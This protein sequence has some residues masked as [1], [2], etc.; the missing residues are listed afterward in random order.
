VFCLPWLAGTWG[1][2]AEWGE[3]EVDYILF[4]KAD[5]TLQPN[6]EE[7][8]VSERSSAGRWAA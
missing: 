8:M 6:P 1:P 7:V 2:D 5:V 3:H 4:M